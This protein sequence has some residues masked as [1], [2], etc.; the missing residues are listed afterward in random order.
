MHVGLSMMWRLLRRFRRD[1]RGS[2]LVVTGLAMPVLVGTAA[3]GTEGGLWYV[4]HRAIQNA[5]DSA[6]ISAATAYYVQ[7]NTT[8]LATQG[9]AVAA[10]YGYVNGA[11]G[12]TV[13]VNQ[14][15][16]SGPHATT[17]KAVEVIIH[18]SQTRLLS[19]LWSAD[20][21]TIAARAVAVGNGGKGC[22][23]ALDPTAGG[24][25]TT[26][27]TANVT[28]NGCAL[29]DNS[30]S[31]SAL[32]VGGSG[33]ISAQSVSVVGGISGANSITTTDGIASGQSPIA[34]PYAD[35]NYPSFSGCRENNYTAKNTVTL[36]PGVYCGGLG[37]NAGAN[38]TL[39]AGIYY[40]DRGSLTVNGGATL[41][42]TGVTIV[43][44]SSN[45]H[46]Y[47][48]AT[49]NGG[50][51]VNLTAPT[52][53]PTAGIVMFGDR[54][55]PA[56]TPIKLNGGS[57]EV[58]QGAVYIP[59]G[60]VSFAGGA[61]ANNGC[62][63]MVANTITFTGNANFAVNCDASGTKAIGSALARLVE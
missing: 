42:G 29:Y 34:D 45:G 1:Q 54:G 18:A 40:M 30:S 63:Q 51:N 28:L 48:T 44:T 53:G 15:P 17:P 33:T 4:R 50:A 12:V 23:I 11:S 24:A 36:D 32:T 3:L 25:I 6:A 56:D 46:N 31:T 61:A 62:L 38:V 35:T 10:G 21:L 7:G 60:A 49:I 14:P 22:V 13:T 8:G 9:Q 52:T 47:A 16:T 19:T 2:Y 57:S 43:F 27:G 55:M 39:N 41:S 20:P 37:L 58:L 26:Q 59:K 5:A